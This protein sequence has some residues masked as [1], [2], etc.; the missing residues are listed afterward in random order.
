MKRILAL[1][2]IV[3]VAAAS[4]ALAAKPVKGATY[5]GTIVRSVGN[6]SFPI[7]FK[8]SKNGKTV[9]G[10]KL[11]NDYPVY[12]QGGGFPVLGTAK[13]A[14]ISKQGKFTAKLP[15]KNIR[16]PGKGEGSVIITGKFAAHSSVS[17]TVKTDIGGSAFKSC[18][19]SSP[20]RATK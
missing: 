12:C 10:F 19:G 16:P 20:F 13:A 9:S 3:A 6:V 2:A 5:T 1:T 17:G 4:A 8:V 14:K 18:N 7:S 11:T 15:L